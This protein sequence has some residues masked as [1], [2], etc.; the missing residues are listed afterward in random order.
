V[1]A[2]LLFPPSSI[3]G[4]P[5]LISYAGEPGRIGS[6]LYPPTSCIEVVRYAKVGLFGLSR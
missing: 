6:L 4:T 3:G 2:L 5:S 1:A